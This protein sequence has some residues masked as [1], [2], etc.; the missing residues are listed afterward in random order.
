M[1]FSSDCYDPDGD[2]VSSTTGDSIIT[3]FREIQLLSITSYQNGAKNV[4]TTSASELFNQDG[5]PNIPS[6]NF[7]RGLHRIAIKYRGQPLDYTFVE[8]TGSGTLTI[9]HK[10]FFNANVYPNPVTAQ[11]QYSI[12]MNTSA[13]LRMTYEI[14]DHF[15]NLVTSTYYDLEEGHSRTH[16]FPSD[17][18]D[19]NGITVHKFSFDDGSYETITTIK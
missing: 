2:L 19:P 4:F 17:K 13:R 18:L 12:D 14:Y 5:S 8:I 9:P 3:F 15:G 6:I 10:D 1:G 11:S 7:E 16:V